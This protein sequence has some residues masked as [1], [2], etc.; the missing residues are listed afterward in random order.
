[1]ITEYNSFRKYRDLKGKLERLFRSKINLMLNRIK[2]D[3]IRFSHPYFV[4]EKASIRHNIDHS[5]L[6]QSSP[7]N[8]G[9]LNLEK[10]DLEVLWDQ[11]K[12]V[13]DKFNLFNVTFNSVFKNIS[14]LEQYYSNP[15]KQM[16][17]MR[18]SIPWKTSTILANGDVIINNRCFLYKCGNMHDNNFKEIWK[19]EKYRIFRKQLKQNKFFPPCSRCCGAVPR[20]SKI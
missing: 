16:S 6:G 7:V 5:G 13:H 18:C 15:E 10:I 2:V 4:T 1:M 19:G 12:L 14:A 3:A 9:M 17:N 20:V 8:I 11:L